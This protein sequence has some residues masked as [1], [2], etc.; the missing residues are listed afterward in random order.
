MS[1]HIHLKT[2]TLMRLCLKYK[3]LTNCKEL[4]GKFNKVVETKKRFRNQ[5]CYRKKE[6]TTVLLVSGLLLAVPKKFTFCSV[7]ALSVF[8]FFS[9]LLWCRMQRTLFNRP[10]NNY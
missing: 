2:G 6:R 5:E 4:P 7:H 9:V 10:F 1:P 8:L 3:N